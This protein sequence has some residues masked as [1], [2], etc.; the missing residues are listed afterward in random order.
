MYMTVNKDK[1]AH[2]HG[3][4]RQNSFH[5]TLYMAPA[6]PSNDPSSPATPKMGSPL[7]RAVEDTAVV[8]DTAADTSPEPL[9]AA[10]VPRHRDDTKRML[11]ALV[12][13]LLW[14]CRYLRTVA[15]AHAQPHRRTP[16]L[17]DPRVPRC[18]PTN[19]KAE[20]RH[21]AHRRLT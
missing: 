5:K 21:G 4:G 10:I 17:A 14:A 9:K 7:L 1:S 19:P 11:R 15:I 3:S 2:V 20:A 18:Q 6:R 12:P 13:T 8:S 16:A